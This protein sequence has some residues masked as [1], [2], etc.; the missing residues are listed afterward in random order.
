MVM[1]IIIMEYELKGKLCEGISGRVEGKG[2][3]IGG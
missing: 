3:N 1:M 2:D